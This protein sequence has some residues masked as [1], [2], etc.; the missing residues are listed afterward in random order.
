[1]KRFLDAISNFNPTRSDGSFAM[2][3]KISE[4]ALLL[5]M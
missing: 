2:Y 1:M 4:E 3:L 5:L